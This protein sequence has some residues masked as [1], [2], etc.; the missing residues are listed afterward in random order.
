MGGEKTLSC[1]GAVLLEVSLI[2]IYKEVP[3]VYDVLY[4]MKER[5]FVLFDICSLIYRPLDK[6]LYQSDFLFVKED[7]FLR[8][9]KKWS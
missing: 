9:N 5:G 1:A 6:S 4:F 3:L 2:D 7:S 8:A